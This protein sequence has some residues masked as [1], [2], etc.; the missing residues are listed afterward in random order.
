LLVF[1]TYDLTEKQ[2]K[3]KAFETSLS[4]SHPLY[5]R[6]CRSP[7]KKSSNLRSEYTQMK[8]ILKQNISM[9]ST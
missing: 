5:A 1:T 4:E 3:S 2:P 9:W 6:N 8:R 7:Y